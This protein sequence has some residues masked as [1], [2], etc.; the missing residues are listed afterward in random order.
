[1]SE[2]EFMNDLRRELIESGQASKLLLDYIDHI[3]EISIS[4]KLSTSL[5]DIEERL[6]EELKK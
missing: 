6:R 5:A 1:M 2:K 4:N 3:V